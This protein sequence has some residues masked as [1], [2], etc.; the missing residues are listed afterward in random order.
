MT[1]PAETEASLVKK[2]QEGDR[3]AYGELVRCHYQGVMTVVYR[4]CGDVQL[5]EDAAQDAFIQAWQHLSSFQPASSLRNWLYRIAV[6]AALD[7][8]RRKPEMTLEDVQV[9]MVPDAGPGPEGLLLQQEHAALVQQAIMSLA[10]ASRTVLVLREYEGLSYQEIAVTLDI[11]L[12]TVM[13]RLNYARNRLRELL[14]PV[15]MSTEVEY[16]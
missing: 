15:M 5:A 7:V 2:A 13:S 12:G 6:N 4:L 11:P 9:L 8:L 14:E 16:A 3:S 1:F 10:P